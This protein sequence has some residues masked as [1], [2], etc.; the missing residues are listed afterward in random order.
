[1]TGSGFQPNLIIK[2]VIH[3]HKHSSTSLDYGQHIVLIRSFFG[4]TGGQLCGF[5]LTARYNIAGIWKCWYPTPV[6]QSCIPT[7]MVDVKM[8]TQNIV[9]LLWINA[10]LLQL[11]QKGTISAVMPVREIA[12]SLIVAYATVY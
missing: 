8:G 1:M 3:L 6:Y 12:T 10:R 2:S 4:I 9:N 7:A 11:L 5:K